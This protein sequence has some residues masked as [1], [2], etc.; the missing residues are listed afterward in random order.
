MR[1]L[2]AALAALT[3][4]ACVSILPDAEPATLYRLDPAPPPSGAPPQAGRISLMRAPTAFVTEAANDRIMTVNNGAVA[5][6]AGAR[7]VGPAPVLFDEA[8]AR[9]FE[10]RARRTR[11][12]G[13]GGGGPSALTLRLEVRDFAAYYEGG[14]GTAPVAVIRISGTIVRRATGEVVSERAFVV[15]STA[16]ANRV[17]G[18]VGAFQAA[19]AQAL[20]EVV[21]WVD[22]AV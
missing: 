6:V 7:W 14:E 3:L 8:L 13:P 19:Q 16:S 4:S 1:I 11:L 12:A 2:L 15:R 5:Y 22:G 9:A 17:S 18:V 20:G 21:A 10:T